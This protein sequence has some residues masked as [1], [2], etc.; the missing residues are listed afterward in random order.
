MYC[1]NCGA[2]IPDDARFCP[3]CGM[4]LQSTPE[5]ASM[6]CP[7]CGAELYP[8]SIFCENCGYKL[9]GGQP[10]YTA[11]IPP[12]PERARVSS[13]PPAPPTRPERQRVSDLPPAP[14][15]QPGRQ[16]VPSVPPAPPIPQRPPEKSIPQPPQPEERESTQRKEPKPKKKSGCIVALILLILLALAAG[17]YFLRVYEDETPIDRMFPGIR[18]TT[19]SILTTAENVLTTAK[20]VLTKVP[21]T[22]SGI[23]SKPT[24]EAAQVIDQPTEI[25][26]Q[27][28][29]QPT[30][31]KAPVSQ[32]TAAS[33]PT[34]R[35]TATAIPAAKPTAAA[36][37]SLW[38][39]SKTVPDAQPTAAETVKRSYNANDYTTSE[40]SKLQDFLW[41]T[42]DIYNGSLPAGI[43]R[44]NS[45]D[46][47]LGGWKAW[48]IDEPNG[49]NGTVMER[50]CQ[51]NFGKDAGGSGMTITW[52]YVHNTKTDEGYTDYTSPTTFYGEMQNG[53]F[54]GLG[55]GSIDMTDFYVLNGHEYAVGTLHW[56]DNA[57]GKVFLARP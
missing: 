26:S 22:I 52:V 24:E 36:G 50:L 57:R 55:I 13:V 35:P 43:D 14:P 28:I 34:I 9:S 41:V 1:E 23:T 19:E 6:H 53:R 51:V 56:P 11:E 4:V 16:R 31:T 30:V 10:A 18:P 46:E 54:H 48:I 8:D 29:I 27:D 25:V 40:S 17:Y 42:K 45:F 44:L 21:E 5:P 20:T 7:N 15:A 12:V 38:D 2:Y 33:V 49:Q 47:L 3:E 39:S 32:P 37:K